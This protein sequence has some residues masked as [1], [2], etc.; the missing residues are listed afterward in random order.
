MHSLQLDYVVLKFQSVFVKVQ[1][2]LSLQFSTNFIILFDQTEFSDRSATFEANYY[3][4]MG[5]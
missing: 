2:Q 4:K 1:R 5:D 3:F